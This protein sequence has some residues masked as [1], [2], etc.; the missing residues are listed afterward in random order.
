MTT[1]SGIIGPRT[2]TPARTIVVCT[3]ERSGWSSICAAWTESRPVVQVIF[4]LRLLAIVA[5]ASFESGAVPNARTVTLCCMGRLCVTWSIYL[6]NGLSDLTGDRSNGSTRP[7]AQGTLNSNYARRLVIIL[8]ATGLGLCLLAGER[9]FALGTVMITLG[10]FYSAGPSPLKNSVCGVQVSVVGGG[11][12]TYAAGAS[13]VGI[14]PTPA[15]TLF[16]APSL[17]GW[18][19]AVCRRTCRTWKA[20]AQPDASH[21]RCGANG[22]PTLSSRRPLQPWPRASSWPPSRWLS[23]SSCPQCACVSGQC[24]LRSVRWPELSFDGT[25]ELRITRSCIHNTERTQVLC[26]SSCDHR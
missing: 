17:P 15:A 9:I 25:H 8:A 11:L 3:Q 4:Q 23:V 19:S 6:L 13:A 22:A 5:V 20:T 26:A 1:E 10:F 12:V 14:G 18:P 16:A 7:L 2:T 24:L 21:W